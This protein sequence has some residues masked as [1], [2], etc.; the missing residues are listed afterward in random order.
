VIVLTGVTDDNRLIDR[1]RELGI[2]DLIPK[3]TFGFED[4]LARIRKAI[5]ARTPSPN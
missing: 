4:L 1:A 5:A 3:A 2:I